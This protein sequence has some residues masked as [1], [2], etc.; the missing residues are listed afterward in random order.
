MI[1]SLRTGAKLYING[2]VLRADRK[3]NIELLNDAVFL[4]DA[5]VLQAQ[6]ATTPLRQLYFVI[7]TV[8]MD[9]QSLANLGVMMRSMISRSLATFS[10]PRVLPGLLDV[11]SL[12]ERERHFEALKMLRPLFAFEDEIIARTSASIA[13][14]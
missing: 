14:E 5:H 3:V 10:D 8:L 9:P 4:L 1:L 11:E 2:A 6:D 12:I 13:A 7:Q